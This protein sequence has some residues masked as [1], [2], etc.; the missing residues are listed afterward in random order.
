[1]TLMVAAVCSSETSVGTRRN[2][3]EGSHIY[4]RVLENP[5]SHHEKLLG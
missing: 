3:T 5:K 2:I 4:T 1:M